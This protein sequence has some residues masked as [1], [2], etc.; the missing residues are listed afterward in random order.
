MP[1]V[2]RLF[3]PHT[4]RPTNIMPLVLVTSASGYLASTIAVTL[5]RAGHHVRATMRS[6]AKVEAFRNAW[7]QYQDQLQFVL[8]EDMAVEGCYDE[9]CEGVD[10]IAHSASPFLFGELGWTAGADTKEGN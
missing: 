3:Y 1:C 5:L 10:W 4:T 8:V 9:A 2:A 6:Q 7:P